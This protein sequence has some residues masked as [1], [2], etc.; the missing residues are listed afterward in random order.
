[1]IRDTSG[2]DRVLA[3]PPASPR[4]KQLM[5]GG[6]IA[7][8]L[9]LALSVPT[10]GR[11]L[12]AGQSVSAERVRV[13]EVRRGTLVRDVLVQGRMV[14]A[15]SPTLYAPAGGTV[16][17]K[18]QAGDEIKQGQPLAEIDSPELRSRLVQEQST[19]ASLEAEASRA[20]L[21]AQLTRSTARKLLDQAE[22]DRTAAI[23]DLER[24]QRGFDGGAVSQIEVARAQDSLKKADIGLS[25]AKGE[26]GL[27][28]RGAGLDTRNKH[29]LA[30]RQRAIVA[31]LQRQVDEL[32][33]R[34]PVDG[35]VGTVA[36]TDRTVVAA[37]SPLLVVV[38]LREL[39]VELPVPESYADDMRL[40]MAAEISFGSQK[41]AGKL[42]AVSPEVI[43]GQ[44]MA[45]VRF[46]DTQ[47]GARRPAGL[48]QNQR[49]STRVLIEEKPNVLMV[50]RGPFLD[51]GGGRIAYVVDG[52]TA[53]K[54]P[55]TVGASS[56]SDVEILSGL[57]PGEQ[58]VISDITSFNSADQV[59]IND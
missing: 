12:S 15:V 53:T 44:V 27:Q 2:Q 30:Q 22:I 32:N 23:R 39:E 43:N 29:L 56:L 20:A 55:I 41:Y 26:Y 34:S 31:E 10:L 9:L 47:S 48:R 28:D 7:A 57:E 14:A 54:R 25:H 40:G 16:K 6:G 52:D 19:L 8:V 18:V 11:W 36:I 38:D 58:V 42:R 5:I 17:L 35:V 45:R 51:T 13:A 37:N 49:V 1:M 4:R 3:P 21:D 50:Q 59:L 24:Q 33:I 46:D